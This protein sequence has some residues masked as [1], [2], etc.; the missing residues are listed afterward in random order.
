MT[1]DRGILWLMKLAATSA[2]GFPT[3]D[4][5][6]RNWRFKLETSITSMSITCIC[7]NPINARFF[8]SSQPNPPAPTTRTCKQVLN[9][10]L[11]NKIKRNNMTLQLSSRKSRVSSEAWKSGWARGPLRSRTFRKWAH[12]PFQL[13]MLIHLYLPT[14]KL[15]YTELIDHREA[16]DFSGWNTFTW[17]IHRRNIFPN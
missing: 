12:L 15:V 1:L 11:Y 14:K 6:N 8:K 2:L 10:I 16:I 17:W 4:G 5:R 9:V 13:L 7:L 3:S